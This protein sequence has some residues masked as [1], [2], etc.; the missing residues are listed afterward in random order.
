MPDPRFSITLFDKVLH[1]RSDFNCGVAQID[2]WL[3]GSISQQIKDNRL[4]VWCA[5]N[6]AGRLV[7]FY[8]LCAHSIQPD[9]APSLAGRHER[10]PIPV[11][12]LPAIATLKN[13]QGKGLGAALMG[14]AILKSIGMAKDIGIAAIVL[15]VLE[16]GHFD[17]RMKFY[18]GLGFKHIGKD[19]KR[20]F[21]SIKAAK[22]CL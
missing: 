21:L 10:N 17:K 6:A 19:N 20:V 4:R 15:D 3:Q 11:I 1:D 12:Y 8:A 14:H 18:T 2:T 9:Y 13:Q 22:A 16:D 7:G 5:T